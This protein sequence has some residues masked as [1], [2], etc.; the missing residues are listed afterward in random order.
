MGYHPRGRKESG[1]TE[2][3]TLLLPTG[4]LIPLVVSGML[5]LGFHLLYQVALGS[6]HAP[7]LGLRVGFF[8]DV[9]QQGQSVCACL[10]TQSCQI[11]CNPW[12]VACQAP[13]SMGIFWV[14]ILEW[15]AISFSKPNIG[16]KIKVE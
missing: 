1:M 15:I 12:T 13:L 3:L 11:L 4:S 2:R 9:S 8:L 5:S 14:R 7:A 6:E 10:V 16:L